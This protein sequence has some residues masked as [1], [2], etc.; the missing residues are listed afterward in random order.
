M[1][2]VSMRDGVTLYRP[3]LSFSKARLAAT[4]RTHGVETVDDPSNRNADFA[5]VRM[6]GL[7]DVLAAEGL[8]P[9]RLAATAA[10][11]ARA[12][13][14]LNAARDDFLMHHATARREGFLTFPAKPYAALTEEI[15]L[16]VLSEAVRVLGG[17]A[18]PPREVQIAAAHAAILGDTL[19]GGRTLAGATVRQWRGDILICREPG[20]IADARSIATENKDRAVIWD[21][22]FDIRMEG[23]PAAGLEIGA[24]GTEGV[25]VLR[26][27]DVE[28]L[29]ALPGP[30][31]AGLPTLRKQGR[32]V[33]VPH[34]GYAAD[35]ADLTG[36][37]AFR[38]V[39]SAWG[40]DFRGALAFSN[41]VRP[42][43]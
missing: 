26:K 36:E 40:E 34:V 6:R 28:P 11:M 32:I 16:R 9:T 12:R 42:L 43:M 17:R 20:T 2:P 24:L 41:G 23:S 30:V 37:I 29:E 10:R 22:R 7:Q 15:A 13:D 8:T 35:E 39:S 3:L 19:K 27:A 5:R 1:S 31:R 33:S 38:P 18:Y 21:G 14:S 4:V 25:A